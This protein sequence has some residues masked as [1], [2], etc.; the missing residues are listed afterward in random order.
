VPGIEAST[1]AFV[2][3]S[4]GVD[5]DAPDGVPVTLVLG[6]L[7]PEEASEQHLEELS[8]IAK[9]LSRPALRETLAQAASS[10]TLYDALTGPALA[11]GVGA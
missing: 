8:A 6:L 11:A 9:L 2:R 10:S 5:F 1:A 3:L 7:V 4:Q